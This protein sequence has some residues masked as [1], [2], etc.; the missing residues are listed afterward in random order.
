MSTEPD[1]QLAEQLTYLI[2]AIDELKAIDTEERIRKRIV[3]F[4]R[5]GFWEEV[6]A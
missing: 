5:M 4:G 6:P 3:K 2:N 1:D